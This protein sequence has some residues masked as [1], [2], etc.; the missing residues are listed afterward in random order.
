MSEEETEDG[1]RPFASYTSTDHAR[2]K[3]ATDL[4]M[5]AGTCHKA[6][7]PEREAGEGWPDAGIH[8]AQSIM[9]AARAIMDAAVVAAYESGKTWDQ[10]G[11]AFSTGQG[12]D[13]ITRQ[14]AHAKYA[15]VVEQF[16]EQ[17][18]AAAERAGRGEEPIDWAR[19][20]WPKRIC[21]TESCAPRLDSA[22]A[23]E[24]PG[25]LG[26]PAKPGE[27]TASL[28][29]PADAVSAQVGGWV[30]GPDTRPLGCRYSRPLDEPLDDGM[31]GW[32]VCT[33][34]EGHRGK[35]QL[36]VRTEE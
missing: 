29:D 23:V 19:A 18:L 34:W 33:L 7:I 17:L 9:S 12:D 13:G 24:Y 3:L 21:N 8:V 4:L 1:G 25:V 22:A 32:V 11:R 30:R 6:L 36:A 16:H 31:D 2:V 20:P 28:S 5:L 15:P 27:L 35:H 10:I 14:S 26:T